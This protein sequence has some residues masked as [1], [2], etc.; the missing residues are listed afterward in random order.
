MNGEIYAIWILNICS[1]RDVNVS[2]RE[3]VRVG[4][5]GS[6]ATTVDK[7]NDVFFHSSLSCC[8]FQFL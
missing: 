6:E 1:A 5:K 2:E 7:E 8:C 3:I 4:V